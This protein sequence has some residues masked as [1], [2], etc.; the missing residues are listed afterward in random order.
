M[1]CFGYIC[2]VCETQIVGDCH[3]GGELC[4]LQHIRDDEVIGEVIGHYNEYGGVIEDETYR[5]DDDDNPNNHDEI[6]KS[7][8]GL[9]ESIHF[10][11][12]KRL[13]D[14]QTLDMRWLNRIGFKLKS[15]HS[16]VFQFLNEFKE[17]DYIK[18]DKKQLDRINSLTNSIEELKELYKLKKQLRNKPKETSIDEKQK[19]LTIKILKKE[20]DFEELFDKM[21]EK[22]NEKANSTLRCEYFDKMPLGPAKHG[23][24]A[25]HE[26][27][28]QSLHEDEKENLPF[29]LPDPE[30][31]WGEVREEFK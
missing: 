20:K 29:S 16:N 12:V 23:T 24:I 8:F 5:N 25:V 7:E 4:R 14:G 9:P 30:Q 15:Y 19:E 17:T 26:K 13:K 18:D 2:S 3:A 11:D 28:Y 27:C 6:C 10:G 21:L 31:S 1:G 22:A